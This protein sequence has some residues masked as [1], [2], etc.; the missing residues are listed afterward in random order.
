MHPYKE[1][2]FLT[3]HWVT[4]RKPLTHA[5]FPAVYQTTTISHAEYLAN[6]ERVET[7]QSK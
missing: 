7:F 2:F 6:A 4:F 5:L 1:R 3:T